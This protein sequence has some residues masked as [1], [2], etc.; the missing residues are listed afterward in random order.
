[1]DPYLEHPGLWPGVHNR[2]IGALDEYLSP[3]L[4]PRYYVAL[5]ERVYIAEPAGLSYIGRPD[6]VV[7][8]A[9]EPT[10]A[11][12]GELL[13]AAN[14]TTAAGRSG[15]QV[16]IATV[17]VP[18]RIRETYLEVREA[19]TG[20]VVTLIEVLSPANKRP[21]EGRREYE[22][23]RLHTLGTLTHLVEIDLLRG[24]QPLPLQLRDRP[25]A[26]PP[27]DYRVLI[28]RGDRRPWAELYAFGV[29]DPLPPFPLPLRLGDD[30]P[31]V[32][33]QGILTTVYDRA[34]Y[35][36]RLDY[37][38]DSVPP[39]SPADATWADALLR[40]SGHRR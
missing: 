1:M 13:A 17:P 23:K 4:R 10:V 31:T 12:D 18:D 9:G 27:G 35:D 11:P 22:A 38:A 34:S 30:E 24:G 33:L 6:A 14:G 40:E 26:L 29:R 7:V 39:L 36:L 20:A 19:A 21:G 16:L 8:P 5:E 37:A 32:D 2:L 25:D 28:A 3:R 15:V